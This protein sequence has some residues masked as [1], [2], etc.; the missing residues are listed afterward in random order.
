LLETP[1]PVIAYVITVEGPQPIE[2][3]TAALDYEHYVATQIRPV[4]EQV[5]EWSGTSWE[6]I[7]TGQQS[8]F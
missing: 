7:T 6:R 3:R 5:E 1:P 2:Q 8:L 4:F